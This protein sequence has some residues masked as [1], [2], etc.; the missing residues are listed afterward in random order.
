MKNF[1]NLFTLSQV[2]KI[3]IPSTVN[4]NEPAPELQD[5]FTKEAQGLL[6]DCFGGATTTAAVGSYRANSGE[7]VTESVNVVYAFCTPSQMNENFDR[8]FAFCQKVCRDMT[9]EAISL[10]Y[11]GQLG[12]VTL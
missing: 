7:L 2:V 10:E 12:F 9:Q 11:N 4:V 5:K 6:S 1:S 3:Y 8:V